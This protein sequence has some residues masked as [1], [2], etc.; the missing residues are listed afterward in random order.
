MANYSTKP[1]NQ[2]T[3]DDEEDDGSV[4]KKYFIW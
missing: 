3:G 2:N 1:I 4:I